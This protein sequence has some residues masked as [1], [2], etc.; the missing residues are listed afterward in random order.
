MHS[1]KNHTRLMACFGPILR[2]PLS[3]PKAHSPHPTLETVCP[4]SSVCGYPKHPFHR[5][6]RGTRQRVRAH[7]RESESL[8]LGAGPRRR[9]RPQHASLDCLYDKPFCLN[10]AGMRYPS[11]SYSQSL[12]RVK[13]TWDRRN[14]GTLGCHGCICVCMCVCVLVCQGRGSQR[15]FSCTLVPLSC[16]P[17]IWYYTESSKISILS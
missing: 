4:L 15:R 11:T 5:A 10:T 16:R 9:S 7:E 6:G 2:A 8:V 3:L 1:I 12:E 13:M 17:S 14:V